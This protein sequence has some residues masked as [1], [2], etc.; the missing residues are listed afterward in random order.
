[1]LRV[2]ASVREHRVGPGVVCS[3]EP[4]PP[5]PRAVT[6]RRRQ[7]RPLAAQSSRPPERYT[8]KAVVPCSHPCTG[9]PCHVL[10]GI[11]TL[12][13]DRSGEEFVR[14]RRSQRRAAPSTVNLGRCTWRLSRCKWPAPGLRDPAGARWPAY[15][16]IVELKTYLRPPAPERQAR[17]IWTAGSVLERAEKRSLLAK[18]SLDAV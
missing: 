15:P 6:R 18:T 1:M 10:N 5:R 12:A 9:N 11:V 8:L 13:D 14:A 2:H 3:L 7:Q 16:R 17:M 4:I